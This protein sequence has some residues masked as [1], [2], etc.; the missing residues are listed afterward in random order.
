MSNKKTN[1]A[2]LKSILEK[3]K[4]SFKDEEDYEEC[5][6]FIEAM[7]EEIST[8]ITCF[9]NAKDDVQNLEEKNVEL[10]NQ[11][12]EIEDDEPNKVIQAGI[13]TIK[14]E[15]DNLQLIAIMENLGEKL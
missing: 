13:G 12:R 2:F 8:A 10:S 4:S 9:D 15:S 11:I 5:L 7:E 3:N 1:A 6:E 14:W